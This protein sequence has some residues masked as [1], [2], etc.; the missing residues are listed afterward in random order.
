MGTSLKGENAFY[1][2]RSTIQ[3]SGDLVKMWE[4]V[5]MKTATIIEGKRVFSMRNLWE[6]DCRGSRRRMLAATAYAGHLGKGAV[7]GSE[8][9]PPPVPWTAVGAS[10][11]YAQYF[12]KVACE[13]K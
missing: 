7:V 10:D 12:R 13:R 9:F 4:M 8:N 1:A 5:D 2:A 11:G 6:Y 3:R